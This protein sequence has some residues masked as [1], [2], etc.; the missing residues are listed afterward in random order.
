MDIESEKLILDLIHILFKNY[1]LIAI[2]HR[3][4]TIMKC[5]KI[6]VLDKGE[7]VEYDTPKRLL[8]NKDSYF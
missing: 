6:L 3:I 7:I 4:P 8:A 1:T 5:D 2:A